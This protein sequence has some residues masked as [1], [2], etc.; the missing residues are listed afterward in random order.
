M[1][2][3]LPLPQACT[4]KGAL[5]ARRLDNSATA[6]FRVR[7]SASQQWR[8]YLLEIGAGRL[9]DAQGRTIIPPDLL[10][11][12]DIVD[13]IYGTAI[14]SPIIES[15][16]NKAILAPKNV[17]VDAVN[18][19]VLDRLNV[20]NVEEERHFKSIDEIADDDT[21]QHMHYPIE[22]LNSLNPP[23]VPPHDLHLKKGAIVMLLHHLDVP[24]M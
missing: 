17:D 23:G 21:D 12:G 9:K 11:H 4:C 8:D 15:L 7:I 20:S 5:L 16:R 24:N 14:S 6:I 18:K 19:K 13:E 2:L 1:N 3:R 10:C 22:Y